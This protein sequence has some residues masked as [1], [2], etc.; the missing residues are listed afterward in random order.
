[1]LNI[2]VTR[3]SVHLCCDI[4]VMTSWKIS[5]IRVQFLMSTYKLSRMVTWPMTSRD[6]IT[7]QRWHGDR[8]HGLAREGKRQFT[9]HNKQATD[10][11]Q[12]VITKVRCVRDVRPVR[13]TRRYCNYLE[14]IFARI[15]AQRRIIN[16]IMAS[17]A[18]T[19]HVRCPRS[20]ALCHVTRNVPIAKKADC[21][22]HEVRYSC[23]TE[24]PKSR[25][26]NSHGNVTM[27]LLTSFGR[28]NFSGSVFRCVFA[29][30][31]NDHTSHSKDVWRRE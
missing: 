10:K 3:H 7:S 25:V 2:N 23:R 22:A 21:T 30:W 17:I 24:P 28:G 16:I 6:R 15:F 19:L 11:R 31:L 29:L 14:V 27:L 12:C 13:F 20:S 26:W 5:E 4:I 8:T 18:T 9:R 1:M